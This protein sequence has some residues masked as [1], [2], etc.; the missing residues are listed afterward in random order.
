MVN[1]AGRTKIIR[2]PDM[3]WGPG[4]ADPCFKALSNSKTLKQNVILL[5][6]CYY[7]LINKIETLSL[8]LK[9]P[10]EIKRVDIKSFPLLL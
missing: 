2:G 1:L 8:I 9:D 5:F 3:T 10:Q 6:R 4:V 7:T